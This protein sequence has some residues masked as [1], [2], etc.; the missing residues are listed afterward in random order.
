[1]SE[2]DNKHYERA[3]TP[4]R[5][6]AIAAMKANEKSTQFGGDKGNPQAQD[7]GGNKPWSIRN[8]LRALARQQID[9]TDPK[10]LEKILPKKPTVA[11]FIAANAL[12][13]ATK[14]DMR[15]VEYATDQIDG[16]LAQTNINADFAALQGM[17]D[18]ELRAIADGVDTAAE[19]RGGKTGAESPDRSSGDDAGE[20]A[21]AEPS[22]DNPSV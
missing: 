12:A 20:T 19:A 18:D 7:A 15:A 10:A 6:A 2:D 21:G 4:G 9:I 1:M 13:K 17:T 8:S 11:Q 3:M 5:E 16:K 14:A 22:P